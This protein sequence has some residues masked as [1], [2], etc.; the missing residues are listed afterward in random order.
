MQWTEFETERELGRGATARVWLA[1]RLSDGTPLCLKVFHPGLG[2]AAERRILREAEFS[3]SLIHPNIVRV[4]GAVAGGDT[5][6]LALELLDG[7]NLEA[8]QATLPYVLPEVSVAIVAEV[9][10][11]L[12]FAHS[13]G[14]IHRDLKPGNVLLD[15]LGRVAVA[16]FGLAHVVGNEMTA[17]MGLL[18]SVDY[19]SPE[20]VSGEAARASSDLFSVAALLYFLVTG[21]RPFTRL[22]AA[23]TMAAIRTEAPEPP[24]KR[25]PKI[26]PELSRILL[27]G[28]DKDPERRFKDAVEFR[29]ALQGYLGDLRLLPFPLAEWQKDP[30]GRTMASLEAAAEALIQRA[31]V[32]L[33]R[34]EWGPFLE[35]LSHL[36]LKAPST[37][38]LARL[39]ESYRKAK[40]SRRRAAIFF[41]TGSVAGLALLVWGLWPE[42][43]LL[44]P[45]PPAAVAAP[46]ALPKVAKPKVG[47]VQF[48]VP[49]SV[50]VFW[51]G[52]KID[53]K[54]GLLEEKLGEHWLLMEREGF[55]PIRSKVRVRAEKP[56]VIQVD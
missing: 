8:H 13:L 1:R 51:D 29:G 7:G 54:L 2:E 31:E 33:V 20:Q 45:V 50:T 27:K 35:T 53:P 4:L 32:Q 14:V 15:K 47:R 17:S 6:V 9:L 43:K 55:A 11:A 5:A 16:D 22:S 49:D 28:L 30:A 21:T 23:A 42:R 3:A 38:A 26:S 56:T 10:K 36:S 19:L 37:P 25:N 34:A 41:W 52:H 40:R 46:D 39:T 12:E 24:Q 18:G 44:K 48:K